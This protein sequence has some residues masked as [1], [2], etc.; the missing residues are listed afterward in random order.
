MNNLKKLILFLFL[1]P[2]LSVSTKDSVFASNQEAPFLVQANFPPNQNPQIQSG[3]YD[4]TVVPGQKQ[5]ISIDLIN[6]SDEVKKIRVIATSAKTTPSV[7][8]NYDGKIKNNDKSLEHDFSKFGFTP[9]TLKIKPKSR[10]T[11]PLSFT[12]PKK[13]FKGAILGGIYVS[14][15]DPINTNKTAQGKTEMKLKNYLNYA[16][17]VKLVEDRSTEVKP[18][19]KI[20]GI[21]AI[22][23][24]SYPATGVTIRNVAPGI[25]STVSVKATTYLIKD[26]KIR[27]N[28]S[29]EKGTIAPNTIFTYPIVWQANKKMTPGKYHLDMTVKTT[30]RD[31][32]FSRDYTITPQQ[33]AQIDKDNPSLKKSYLWLIILIIV[34]VVILIILGFALFFFM[35]R[36]RGKQE[37]QAGFP[38]NMNGMQ[39]KQFKAMMREQKRQFKEQQKR[40]K[41]RR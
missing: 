34:V 35:G 8:I 12:V 18:D 25:G 29:M 6:N 24:S 38:Q 30:S 37:A 20:S 32:K 16:I 39:K 23:Y 14:S 1:L 22:S 41:R 3:Y 21:S 13:P 17:A 26:R 31:F 2:C 19:L 10:L 28:A 36:G 27:A 15:V 33:A 4:L 5:E 11:V 7:G 40:Q 9:K